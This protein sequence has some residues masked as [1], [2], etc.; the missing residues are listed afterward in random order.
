MTQK[1]QAVIE[2]F[3]KLASYK[4]IVTTSAGTTSFVLIDLLYRSG[5]KIPVVFID[6]GFL[7]EETQSF[8]QQ[9][10]H[11][12]NGVEFITLKS[13]YAKEVFMQDGR[14]LDAEH[15][16]KKIKSIY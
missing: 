1:E 13:S 8:F 5:V 16:C 14:I 6:T 11:I 10:K 4:T 15:C 12:Y 7:F 9:M 2:V 3:Q